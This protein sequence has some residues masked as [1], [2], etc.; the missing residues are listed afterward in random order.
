MLTTDEPPYEAESDELVEAADDG[1]GTTVADGEARPRAASGSPSHNRNSDRARE[2]DG[3][4][5]ESRSGP[6]D[7]TAVLAMF[8]RLRGPRELLRGSDDIALR[9]HLVMLH[10]SLVEHCA[11]N[12]VASGEPIED[13][14]QEGYVG[15]IK[16]VDR[17]D[18]DKGVRFSTYAC[19]LIT[20]EIR[21]YL[22][23][24]G[25]LI[26]EPGWH[27]ELR[28]RIARST[29][30]LTQKLGR[31]P[32]PEEVAEALNIRVDSVRD[33][34]K[35]QMVLMVDS[36]DAGDSND[37]EGGDDGAD[38][39]ASDDMPHE[40]LVDNRMMLDA[41]LP[42]LREL[43]KQ[44]VH[45]FFFEECSKTDIARQL[46]ISVNYAA[47]LI[48]QGT[49]HLRQIIERS[50]ESVLTSPLHKRA[51]YLLALLKQAA[52][53]RT[54]KKARTASIGDNDFAARF[55]E[56][57]GR[58]DEESARAG[59][60]GQEF[61]LLWFHVRNWGAATKRLDAALRE[62]AAREVLRLS[63]DCCRNVDRLSVVPEGTLSNLH[64]LILMPHT[65]EGAERV[66]QRLVVV[67][68]PENLDPVDA[69]SIDALDS[70]FAVTVFPRHANSTESL[71]RHLGS[72]LKL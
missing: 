28:Q 25:K 16:A 67:C 39:F 20:G 72:Q 61:S 1:D 70:E 60:Y 27:S 37:D 62:R 11:R 24:L 29:D 59:R 55:A 43:E 58:I 19:H 65:G 48:K 66:G 4:P 10:T 32:Q 68:R 2:L 30:Q 33:V 52:G 31:P 57:A 64:L 56:L 9:D 49:Q 47:Y 14:L 3:R 26:H 22:R 38:E 46:D 7:E 34:L 35:N 41:A 5:R 45:L 12:F 40:P 42:Q 50:D 44:A 6:R 54:S 23:D 63:E 13:L 8:E 53:G 71:F 51:A 15:L 17:F 21:H 18:P 36:L 69:D